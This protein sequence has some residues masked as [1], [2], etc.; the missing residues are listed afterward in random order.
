MTCVWIVLPASDREED[1]MIDVKRCGGELQLAG[2]DSFLFDKQGGSEEEV[3]TR[4]GGRSCGAHGQRHERAVVRAGPQR[5][6]QRLREIKDR[7][8]L[9]AGQ[10]V[11]GLEMRDLC[12]SKV[13]GSGAGHQRALPWATYAGRSLLP[14]LM[15]G[16]GGYHTCCRPPSVL[17]HNPYS[18]YNQ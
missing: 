9:P 15:D 2:G 18:E 11:Q 10:E 14:L 6:R 16:K 5:T 13:A 8:H 12:R 1:R 3:I 4:M 17:V 7:R